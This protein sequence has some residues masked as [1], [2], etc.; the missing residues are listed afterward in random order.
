MDTDLVGKRSTLFSF[1]FEAA[2]RLGSWDDASQ[3]VKAAAAECQDA[4]IYGTMADVMLASEAPVDVA[5]S[6]LQQIVNITWRLDGNDTAKL[7]RCIR[8][9][10]QLALTSSPAKAEFLL[11][12]ILALAGDGGGPVRFPED[13]L[14]WLATTAFNRAVD[15]YC[16]AQDGDCA[17]WG[18]KAL[19]IARLADDGGSLHDHL[20]DKYVGLSWDS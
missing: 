9:L 8:C 13:E 7:S 6:I 15:F 4:G 10:F 14:A 18:E 11:D 3:I 1:D 2:V 19:R 12:R 20:Q 5:V 17:R 16:A